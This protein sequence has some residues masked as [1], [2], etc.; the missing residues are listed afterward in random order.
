VVEDIYIPDFINN[1]RF[2]GCFSSTS[3]GLANR[4]LP[5]PI[6]PLFFAGEHTDYKGGSLHAAFLSGISA[7]K[8]V[9]ERHQSRYCPSTFYVANKRSGFYYKRRN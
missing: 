2:H 7:A 3:P 4:T 1:P 9:I 6:T 8:E 5:A